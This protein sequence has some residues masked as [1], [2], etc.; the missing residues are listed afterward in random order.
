MHAELEDFK[1]GWYGVT[2]YLREG[3][4]DLL[5]EQL[6]ELRRSKDQHSHVSISGDSEAEGGIAY[7]EFKVQEGEQDDMFFTG[8]SIRPTW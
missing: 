8:F 3:E 6:A 7:T 4:I 1:T 5:I 2:I